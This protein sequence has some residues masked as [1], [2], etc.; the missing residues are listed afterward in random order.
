[1]LN[2]VVC[3]EIACG[4]TDGK[5]PST[6]GPVMDLVQLHKDSTHMSD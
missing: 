1:M 2:E 4:L 6:V 5:S 3:D